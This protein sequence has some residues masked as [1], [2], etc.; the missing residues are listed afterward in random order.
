MSVADTR[1]TARPTRRLRW[2][3]LS[4]LMVGCVV[5]LVVVVVA[6]ALGPH[7]APRDADQ[8]DLLVGLAGPDSG[9]WL[10]TD[11]VGRDIF[12][13]VVVGSRTAI[14]GPALV[15]LGSAVI[16]FVL[17]VLS[18]YIGG[19]TDTTLMRWVDV[20]Y[21]LPG[22]LV[23]IVIAGVVGASYGTATLLLIAFMAPYTT[24][25]VRAAVL[26]QRSAAYVEA[27]QVLGVSRRRIMFVHIGPNVFPEVVAITFLQ[28]ALALLTLSSLSFLGL[29][30]APGTPDWG[31]MAAE[32][33]MLVF[34]NPAAALAPSLLI[35]L[36]AA[37]ANI[38]GDGLFER[39]TARGRTR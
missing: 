32:N 19:R 37:C 12:S 4:P 26:E 28:F 20:M 21:A 9:H 38:A 33:R 23:I 15:A 2:V 11:D 1:P 24:R 30:V 39:L 3:A 10:G 25:V 22:L 8:Q 7:I 36:T 13:R 27:A 6:A 34:E 14:V 29:G 17:G 31:L 16:G 5:F 35:V 18:G